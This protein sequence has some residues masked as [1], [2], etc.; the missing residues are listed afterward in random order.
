VTTLSAE[1]IG[2]V[3]RQAEKWANELIDLD[4]RNTMLYYRD[5]KTASLDLTQSDQ[6]AVADLLSGRKT[7]LGALFVN[8]EEHQAAC[9][10]ARNLRRKLVQLDEEQGIE[11]GRLARGLFCVDPPLTKGTSPLRPLRAPLLLQ[12]LSIRA[13]T[14][15]ENDFVLELGE[16]PEI[17][18][19]LLFVLN[20]QYGVDLDPAQ[21][22]EKLDAVLAR[23]R[24]S[25]QPGQPRR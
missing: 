12:R 15:A 20:R 25:R 2:V 4:H 13:K 17:N 1:R 8:P 23:A 24:G 18:P 6:T 7:R 19:V 11:A 22:S 14:A 9:L 21:V 5:T 16:E 10:R 3:Q